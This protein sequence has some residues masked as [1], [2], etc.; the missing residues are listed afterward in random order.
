MRRASL[1]CCRREVALSWRLPFTTTMP[2]SC[3]PSSQQ[4]A[5]EAAL[6]ADVGPLGDGLAGALHLHQGAPFALDRERL[7]GR[8]GGRQAEQRQPLAHG[9]G[10]RR[11]ARPEQ[12]PVRGQRVEALAHGLRAG[13]RFGLRPLRPPPARPRSARSRAGGR[14]RVQPGGVSTVSPATTSAIASTIACASF[15][16]VGARH[17]G[18]H[19]CHDHPPREHGKLGGDGEVRPAQRDHARVLA[20]AHQLRM[21]HGAVGEVAAVLAE[22]GAERVPVVADADGLA[23]RAADVRGAPGGAFGRGQPAVAVAALKADDARGGRVRTAPPR[24]ARRPGRGSAPP[25]R[26]GRWSWSAAETAAAVVA[27]LITGRPVVRRELALP[28]EQI[29]TER[30]M[31]SGSMKAAS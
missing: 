24:R 13:G 21:Q 11:A 1:N 15:A 3:S 27:P 7:A 12:P 20:C 16:R 23:L 14:L 5:F 30:V 19:G 4:A 29:S 2:F 25:P 6:E 18:E 22:D 31:L 10:E 17:V 28:L 8:R 9:G 26:C